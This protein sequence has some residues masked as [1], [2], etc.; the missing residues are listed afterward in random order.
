MLPLLCCVSLGN[1]AFVHTRQALCL[2][3][4]SPGLGTCCAA[5]PELFPCFTWLVN[6]YSLLH[7]SLAL[8]SVDFIS[9][10]HC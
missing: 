3:P 7:I 10:P 5:R 1:L 4:F 2:S 8:F 9:F 6:F